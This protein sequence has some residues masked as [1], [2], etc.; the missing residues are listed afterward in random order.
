MIDNKII[1]HSSVNVGIAAALENGL[2][3]P[4]IRNTDQKSLRELREKIVSL[5][6]RAKMG[7]L[8][9]DEISGGTFTV[10]TLGMFG[11]DHF[12]PVIN[13]PESA[14]LGVCRV[15]ERPVVIGGEVV[16]RPMSI[17]ILGFDHRLIDGAVGAKFMAR[18][19]EL[20]EDPTLLIIG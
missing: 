4:V 10:T 19:R 12:T 13:P 16:I 7:Q 17:F 20:M 8:T 2:I 1:F 11:S 3:V 18:F 9:P 14:I 6:S 5:G 15:V